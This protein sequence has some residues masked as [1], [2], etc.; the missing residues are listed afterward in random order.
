M[1][2]FLTF[3]FSSVALNI[4]FI[5]LFISLD[6]LSETRREVE[7]GGSPCWIIYTVRAKPERSHTT[8]SPELTGPPTLRRQ[9]I[10]VQLK[11]K[12]DWQSATTSC[13][14][15]TRNT[16]HLYHTA[17]GCRDDISTTN[18]SSIHLVAIR[19]ERH[20]HSSAVKRCVSSSFR[21]MLKMYGN[22]L[23]SRMRKRLCLYKALLLLHWRTKGG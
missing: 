21:R 13:Y 14:Q 12:N 2:S 11:V 7:S 20:L 16:D 3:C 1:T 18:S 10:T 8:V 4:L 15:C 9:S 17:S 19:I 22:D 6:R 23:L 5:Y